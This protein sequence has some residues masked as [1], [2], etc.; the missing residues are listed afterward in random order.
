ME[1]HQ[2]I[3]SGLPSKA[4]G[5]ERRLD[6]IEKQV[7]AIAKRLLTS[8]LRGHGRCGPPATARFRG[9][10]TSPSRGN[11]I[12]I[13]PPKEGKNRAN[14][15]RGA[16]RSQSDNPRSCS[17][18]TAAGRPAGIS[19]LPWPHRSRRLPEQR[20]QH[21]PALGAKLPRTTPWRCR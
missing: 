3:A 21:W 12:T 7:A 19:V 14:P 4:G 2:A 1:L 13:H 8:Q 17:C 6:T 9:T 15:S 11:D 16:P 10:L 18:P 5:V 20:R